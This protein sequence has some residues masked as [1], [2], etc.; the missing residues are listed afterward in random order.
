ML[1]NSDKDFVSTII[2]GRMEIEVSDVHPTAFLSLLRFIYKKEV[3]IHKNLIYETLYVGEKYNVKDFVESLGFLVT[4]ETVLSFLPFIIHV[5]M[6]HVLYQ[7]CQWIMLFEIK[8]IVDTDSF[9]NINDRI[10][11]HILSNTSLQISE[12]DLFH[13]YVKWADYQLKK[14]GRSISDENRRS[15]MNHIHL[16]RFPIMTPEEFASG[17]AETGILTNEEKL[18]ILLYTT[19]KRP[20]KFSTQ[21]RKW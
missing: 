5:G 12:L 16:I 13:A 21:V 15:V 20:T 2:D 17:P 9:M 10:M 8:R 19:A 18:S 3:I 14:K 11:K 1:C 7:R 6:R 4:Y